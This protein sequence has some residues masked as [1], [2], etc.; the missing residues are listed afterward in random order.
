MS[1]NYFCAVYEVGIQGVLIDTGFRCDYETAKTHIENCNYS[2]QRGVE[3]IIL[4]AIVGG[5]KKGKL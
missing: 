5:S 2:F 3:Y 4:P 1:T